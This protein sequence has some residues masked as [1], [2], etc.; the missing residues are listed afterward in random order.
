LVQQA[1][2][3]VANTTCFNKY[4]SVGN[5]LETIHL[6]HRT[7]GLYVGGHPEAVYKDFDNLYS[8]CQRADFNSAPAAKPLIDNIDNAREKS[9]AQSIQLVGEGIKQVVTR[10]RNS[11]SLLPPKAVTSKI[12]A[13]PAN[14]SSAKSAGMR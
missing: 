11:A 4:F 13:V 8:Q 7:N 9:L 10:A 1:V 6:D 12:P 2:P 14:G 5:T 3:V